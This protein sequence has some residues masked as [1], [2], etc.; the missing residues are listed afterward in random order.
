[1][2]RLTDD[3]WLARVR[4]GVADGQDWE[5]A[6]G[7]A[8]DGAPG[9]P[10]ALASADAPGQAEQAQARVYP[11]PSCDQHWPL[12][13]YRRYELVTT[14]PLRYCTRCY[15]FWAAGDALA[16]GVRDPFDEHH[17]FSAAVAPTR[18]RACGGHRFTP[19]GKCRGCE[20]PAIPYNC[21][22]CGVQMERYKDKGVT[23]DRCKACQGTWF[24]T[25]EIARIYGLAPV[26]GLAM[27][28]VDENAP[29]N[30]PPPAFLALNVLARLF[31]PWLPF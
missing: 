4:A 25:G 14:V 23:V 13:V 27:S 7:R 5:T 24:E 17:A 18:C 19:E 6:V 29:D 10:P 8:S 22:G 2:R 12:E 30:I 20:K 11:C 9:D 16:R 26:Q 3:E 31:L 15:G 1:M 21:P 28:Q